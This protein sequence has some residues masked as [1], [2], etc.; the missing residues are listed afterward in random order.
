MRLRGFDLHSLDRILNNDLWD[1]LMT[2]NA[3]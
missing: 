3:Y 1:L 2:I